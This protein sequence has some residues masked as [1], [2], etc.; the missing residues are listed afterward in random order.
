MLILPDDSL[1]ADTLATSHGIDVLFKSRYE[2]LLQ[3]LDHTPQRKLKLLFFNVMPS[4]FKVLSEEQYMSIIGNTAFPI[5]FTFLHTS[6]YKPHFENEK[7]QNYFINNYK[8]LNDI[9]NEKFDAMITTGA[10]FG[11]KDFLEISFWDEMCEI[12]DWA[13]ENVYARLFACWS[14]F[15]SMYHE[16]NVN[17][18][19]REN[20]HLGVFRYKKLI[21][22]PFLEY[23]DDFIFVPHT[24]YASFNQSDLERVINNKSIIP[25]TH[26]DT[27]GPNILVTPNNRTTYLIDHFEYDRDF[28]TKVYWFD[29]ERGASSDLPANYY[30]DDDMSKTPLVNWR[31]HGRLFYLNW[32]DWVYTHGEGFVDNYEVKYLNKE[33]I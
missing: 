9:R 27:L 32:I 19:T 13:K 6:D 8:N 22:H 29:I 30:P 12:M 28:L 24:R 4:A 1:V 15:A 7:V 17:K 18:N 14:V 21:D 11:Q 2:L 20:R 3:N 16:F 26:R 25:L 23:F 10:N 33:T 5:E 31:A